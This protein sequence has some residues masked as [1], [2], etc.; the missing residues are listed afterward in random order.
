MVAL[1]FSDSDLAALA[2]RRWTAPGAA[3]AA[4]GGAARP[5]APDVG[6]PL[7]RPGGGARAGDPGAAARRLRLVGLRLRPAGGAGARARDR[8]GAAAGR[9]PRGATRGWRRSRRCRR[10]SRR[11]CSPA[12]ARAGR[13]TCGV[14][15][16]A[17]GARSPAPRPVPGEARPVPRVGVW[18]D[19][20]DAGARGGRRRRGGRWCRS[21]S[22]ARCCSRTTM[23]RSTALAA[24][25]EAEGIAALP[26]FVP[27]LRDAGVRRAAR[28][29][30]ARG[31]GRRRS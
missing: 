10:R 6:R 19:G 15:L 1:S 11:R 30:A 17:A 16:R 3:G 31:S 12:S 2:R 4:A 18:R 24:A 8:A 26:V 7:G 20:A 21:C 23:R 27:S 5:A 13:R 9:V 28:A 22:T 25:L 29:G 14:L